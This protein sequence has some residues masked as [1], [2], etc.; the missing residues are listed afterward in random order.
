MLGTRG[1]SVG[2][3]ARFRKKSEGIESPASAS[4]SRTGPRILRILARV[5]QQGSGYGQPLLRRVCTCAAQCCREKRHGNC[6]PSNPTLTDPSVTARWHH[7]SRARVCWR[8]FLFIR[9]LRGFTDL[10]AV[11]VQRNDNDRCDHQDEQDHDLDR[12]QG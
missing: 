2:F 9:H 10:Q 4:H 8:I 3:N 11:E 1:S 7:F 12:K 5:S 6:G